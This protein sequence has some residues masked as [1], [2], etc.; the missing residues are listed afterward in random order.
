MLTE[1]L[2]PQGTGDRRGTGKCFERFGVGEAGLVVADFT[3]DAAPSTVPNPEKLVMVA[4]FGVLG[5]CLAEGVFEVGNVG[6][7]GVQRS[8]MGQGLATHRLFH[9]G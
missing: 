7:R 1:R 3:E 8:E 6:H 9:L 2:S 5:E 4:A